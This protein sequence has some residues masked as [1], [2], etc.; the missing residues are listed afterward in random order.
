VAV[1]QPLRISLELDQMDK[2]L[3]DIASTLVPG[4]SILDLAN[5]IFK[6]LCS[7][8]LDMLDLSEWDEL[9]EQLSQW[10]QAQDG[11]KIDRKSISSTEDVI[12]A[13][14]LLHRKRPIIDVAD[15]G[16]VVVALEV[17]IAYFKQVNRCRQQ[18]FHQGPHP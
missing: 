1:E 17:A 4:R 8:E 6:P 9:P 15:R 18:N 7:S 10:I 16:I 2:A 14:N 3:H 5:T 13:Y 11:L 12:R